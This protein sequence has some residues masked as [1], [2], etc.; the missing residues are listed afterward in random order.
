M[1]DAPIVLLDEATASVD[2]DNEKYIQQAITEL[3]RNKTLIVIAHKLRTIKHASQ[4]V[5]LDKGEI[6]EIGN[7]DSLIA[8]NGLYKELWDRRSVANKWKLQAS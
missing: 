8:E 3:I 6:T 5:V 2:P 7:H 1:K 4:I